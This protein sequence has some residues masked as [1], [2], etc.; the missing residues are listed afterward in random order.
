M[1]NSQCPESGAARMARLKEVGIE[2]ISAGSKSKT[3]KS[4]ENN[5]KLSSGHSRTCHINGRSFMD[6]L[7]ELASM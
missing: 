7:F 2:F 5:E 6:G 4:F 1:M 3:D